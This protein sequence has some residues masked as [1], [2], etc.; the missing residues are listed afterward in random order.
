MFFFS[1]PLRQALLVL[2]DPPCVLFISAKET[3]PQS[4]LSNIDS[5]V[6]LSTVSY[7][8]IDR[9]FVLCSDGCRVAVVD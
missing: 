6:L 2:F 5:L 9:G 8:A 3:V 1:V 4:K 7:S